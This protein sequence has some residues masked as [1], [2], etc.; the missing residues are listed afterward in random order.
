[1]L[2]SVQREK[3]TGTIPKPSTK[4]LK[5][6]VVS[7]DNHEFIGRIYDLSIV[8]LN[9]ETYEQLERYSDCKYVFHI[10]YWLKGMVRRIESLNMVGEMLWLDTDHVQNFILPIS[11]Y[12]WLTVAADAFL[13]R[14][15]SIF[16][17]ALLLTNEIFETELKPKKCTIQNLEKAGVSK[18]VIT[19]LQELL[20]SHLEL[21]QERN[22]RFHRG[23]ERE[24]SSDDEAFRLAARFE[25]WGQGIRGND[26][27]GRRINTKRYFKEGLVEL[28][29]DFNKSNRKISKRLDQL[30][31]LLLIEFENRFSPKFNNKKCGFG[32]LSKAEEKE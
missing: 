20:D 25:H 3:R 11:R 22:T 19:V 2:V 17:C 24:L 14:F 6:Y 27:S 7:S 23:F 32:A 26:R 31:D 15:V 28:Q 29:R 16:D 1:M 9:F 10:N 30:Y 5:Q 8:E 18:D 4:F 12:Q 21:R 13:M